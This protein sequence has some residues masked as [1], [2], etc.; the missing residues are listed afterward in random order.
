MYGAIGNF[1]KGVYLEKYKQGKKTQT[2][3]GGGAQNQTPRGTTTNNL[4][5]KQPTAGNPI[6]H[7]N[8]AATADSWLAHSLSLQELLGNP[9]V[10][11]PAVDDRGQRV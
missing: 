9:G 2:A 1:F 11:G 5:A 6:Q 8:T 4:T 3:L 7:C 10:L